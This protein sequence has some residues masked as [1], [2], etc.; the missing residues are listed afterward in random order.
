MVPTWIPPAAVILTVPFPL[1]LI[2]SMIRLPI[3]SL[4]L[5]APFM[6]RAESLPPLSA[7]VSIKM[8]ISRV[9]IPPFSA[10]NKMCRAL[11]FTSC[12]NLSPAAMPATEVMSA[13][14]PARIA[15]IMRLPLVLD[16]F[17]SAPVIT[18][19]CPLSLSAIRTKLP[20]SLML[21]SPAVLAWAVPSMSVWI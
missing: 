3:S 1:A 17:R 14:P 21:I 9:P 11:T 12:P 19:T 6:A 16:R 20:L 7:S 18:F 10:T 2:A 5:M 15:P 13:R 8:G 4:I